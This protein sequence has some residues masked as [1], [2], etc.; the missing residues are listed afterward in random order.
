M[1][2]KLLRNRMNHASEEDIEEDEQKAVTFLKSEQI[3]IGMQMK[4]GGVQIDFEKIGKL[5]LEGIS[6]EKEAK[7]NETLFDDFGSIAE[8]GIYFSEQWTPEKYTKFCG[9]RVDYG[10]RVFGGNGQWQRIV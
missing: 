5:I 8:T 7:Q 1:A 4:H 9:D 6:L 10:W 3:D 2:M